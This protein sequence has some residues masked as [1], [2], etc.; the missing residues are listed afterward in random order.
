MGSKGRPLTPLDTV[1]LG[2]NMMAG[3]HFQWIEADVGTQN[4]PHE[5]Y[6]PTIYP[7]GNHPI[8]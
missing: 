7:N 2:L 5:I 1:C 4:L 6:P 3:G 8:E